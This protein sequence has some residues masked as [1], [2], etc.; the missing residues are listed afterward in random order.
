MERQG[1]GSQKHNFCVLIFQVIKLVVLK[2]MA[3]KI[4]Y[5][6]FPK[7]IEIKILGCYMPPMKCI[8]FLKCVNKARQ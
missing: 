3:F 6:S 2:V 7:Y 8:I 4:Q 5:L 1:A